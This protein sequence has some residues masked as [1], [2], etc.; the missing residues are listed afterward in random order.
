M[1]SLNFNYAEW[2]VIQMMEFGLTARQIAYILPYAEYSVSSIKRDLFVKCSVANA[3]ALVAK[4]MRLHV[5]LTDEEFELIRKIE[6]GMTIAQIAKQENIPDTDL[7][8]QFA[9][10]FK[11]AHVKTLD[12]LKKTATRYQWLALYDRYLS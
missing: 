9:V 12:E 11:K 6:Q 3:T 2:H 4:A 10:I 8:A 7:N 1:N 5:L